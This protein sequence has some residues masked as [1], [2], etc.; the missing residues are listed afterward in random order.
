VVRIHQYFLPSTSRQSKRVHWRKSNSS[1]SV[2]DLEDDDLVRACAYGERVRSFVTS[3]KQSDRM[4]TGR[5]GA[6]A[7]QVV[8]DVGQLG[9]P[10]DFVAS[11]SLTRTLRW[12]V[13]ARGGM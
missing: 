6:G 9:L 5:G 8:E 7:D 12:L 2:P 11:S 1:S 4:M 10:P 13:C 3:P